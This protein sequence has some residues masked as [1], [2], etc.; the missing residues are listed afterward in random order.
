MV[1]CA[2]G[3]EQ[4]LPG[5]GLGEGAGAYQGADV[6]RG[7]VDAVVLVAVG[8]L[9]YGVAFGLQ[10]LAGVGVEPVGGQRERGG[11]CRGG[12][13]GGLGLQGGEQPVGCGDRRLLRV[14]QLVDDAGG[15]HG[16]GPDDVGVPGAD[17]AVEAALECAEP[18]AESGVGGRPVVVVVALGGAHPHG[19]GVLLA[20]G[21][22]RVLDGAGPVGVDDEQLLA[23]RARGGADG[24]GDV[25]EL[26]AEQG[27]HLVLVAGVGAGEGYGGVLAS[28]GAGGGVV[29][30]A[31]ARALLQP[32][33]I[34]GEDGEA[35][36]GEP[37]G[38]VE[39]G[40]AGRSGGQGGCSS[41]WCGP[42]RRSVSASVD[43]DGVP[44][45]GQ[46]AGSQGAG[47][48]CPSWGNFCSD[49]ERHGSRRHMSTNSGW[50]G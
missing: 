34:G 45:V 19:W 12:R 18:V 29:A 20:E 50:S 11:R 35:V 36:A 38:A 23:V 31:D 9:H 16:A 39:C 37:Q 25:A 27:A 44:R 49:S 21:G 15:V 7:G 40:V 3:G 33:V 42:A 41:W 2:G 5:L 26:G 48:Q 10:C 46:R 43:V 22:G 32:R 1:A 17:V 14:V 24:D 8:C 6:E 4:R 47:Q 30:A 13:G 28:V